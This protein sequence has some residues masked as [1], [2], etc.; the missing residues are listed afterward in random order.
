M[1]KMKHLQTLIIILFLSACNINSNIKRSWKGE[2][3]TTIQYYNFYGKFVDA[4]T[5]KPKRNINEFNVSKSIEVRGVFRH[6]DFE[7][8]LWADMKQTAVKLCG[9]IEQVESVSKAYNQ[10][11]N[12]KLRMEANA[13]PE[14]VKYDYFFNLFSRVNCK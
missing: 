6:S 5:E 10:G 9:S 8:V 1:K 11:D 12:F 7:S 13:E 2:I 14:P 3:E 4:I